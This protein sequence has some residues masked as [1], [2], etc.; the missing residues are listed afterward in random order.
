MKS[1]TGTLLREQGF[2]GRAGIEPGSSAGLSG[3]PVPPCFE[4]KPSPVVATL[5]QARTHLFLCLDMPTTKALRHIIAAVMADPEYC[6]SETAT[7]RLVYDA[8]REAM[9]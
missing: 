1:K 8:I 7:A 3:S 4:P 5:T 6:G 9:K 2:V